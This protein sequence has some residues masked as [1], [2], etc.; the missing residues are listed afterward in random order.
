MFIQ[1]QNE[2]FASHAQSADITYQCLGGNQYQISLSFYRDCAGVAA[3]TTATINISSASCGQNLT[4]TL[5]PIPGTGIDVTPICAQMTTECAGGTYPGVQEFK[6]EGIITLPMQCTDW[7]FSFTLCCRNASINTILNPS[8]ESI[9]VEAVLNNLNFPCNSSPSFSNPPIPFVCIGQPYCFNNGSADTDGDSI[10]YTLIAPRTGP[11]TAVTY[12]APYSAS[13]P[14]LSSPSVT[15]DSETGDMCMWP[16]Q[17]EV[18]VFAILVEEWRNGVLIGSVMR[19]IQLRTVNCTNSNPYVN[20]INN[21][22]QFAISGCVGS[23]INFNIPSF[24]ADASQ[25]VSIHWNNAINGASFVSSG[26]SRPTGSFSWTPA[27]A[28]VSSSGHCFT[29]TVRDDNC[30]YNGS[31]T[32]AFC[33]FVSQLAVN[34]TSTPSN[35]GASNGTATVQVTSGTGPYSYN[36]IGGGSVATQNGLNAGTYTV[37][38]SDGGCVVSAT[39]I[40]STGSAPGNLVMDSS[41]VSCFGI[42][43]GTATANVNGGQA[44]FTYLWSNGAVTSIITG[45]QPGTYSV[46]ITTADGCTASS[47]VSISEPPSPLTIVSS[48]TNNIC[49]GSATGSA[50]V[51]ASGGTGAYTYTWSMG[52]SYNGPTASNL[53]A[54]VYSVTVSDDNSCTASANFTIT[55]PPA[56]ITNAM[57]VHNVSCNGLNNGVATVGASGG[58]GVYTYMWNSNPV[59]Y[60]QTASGLTPGNYHVTVTDAN[61][62]ISVSGLTITEPAPL[63]LAT[64]AFP[65]TCHGGCDGQTVV[66]PSGGSPG[67][68]YQWLPN[69]GTGASATG[70][71][72]GTYSISVFDDNGCNA[73]TMLSVTQPAPITLA[74]SGST[75]ICL[76]QNTNISASANGGTGAYIYQWAGVGNGAVQTVSPHTSTTYSVTVNDANGCSGPTSTVSIQVTS[77]TAANL[78]VSPPAVIC[79]GSNASVSSSVIGNTGP[80]TINWNAGLGNGNGPFTVSPTVNTTYIV[81]VTDA[82]GTFVTGSVPVIVNPLPQVA[83]TPQSLS[84][85]NEATLHFTENTGTNN[86]SNFYW[87]FGDGYASAHT[88]P[89]HTYISSGMFTVTLTVTSLSGCKN[90]ASAICNV[91]VY[92]PSVADFSAEAIDGTTLSPTYRFNN[93]SLNAVSY[94]WTF[95]DGSG[96]TASSPQHTYTSKGEYMITLITESNGGCMD[97]LQ[98]RVEIKPVFTIYIPN[99]FT[100]DGDNTNDFFTAKGEEITE[101]NMMIF[102]RWGEMIFQTNDIQKGW[103]G[104]AKNSSSVAQDGVYVYKIMVRDYEAASHNFTGHVT[105]LAQQ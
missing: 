52:G 93:L 48:S 97:T 77:L 83:L 94:A 10:S 71:C 32:Y 55:E 92:K 87:D 95:G 34:T 72:P 57:I 6:Y 43:N 1:S 2:A 58:T 27:I 86:G 45:L 59:Q 78:L 28:D 62:C 51:L 7:T 49:N 11:A 76:G 40:V 73:I 64:A 31:Q 104:S 42:S 81:T 68:S 103:D 37:N 21:T 22:N 24:D 5:N 89:S 29:V 80:V 53:S 79:V 39:A 12:N 84:A 102:N 15:F 56:L 14:L 18:T 19:D 3:P 85:C 47:S 100:P 60:V 69:G 41:N 50:I 46:T 75:T 82:C 13:Q 101:F 17:F 44:P 96:S 67:Y 38:V 25:N 30:P 20:G 54:G 61:N 99:A 70:L 105:L 33:V 4:L 63:V 23:A 91:T 8:A 9:Y 36:W 98:K 74:A 90:S 88:M 16:S 66:I 26:G 35:C 65:V